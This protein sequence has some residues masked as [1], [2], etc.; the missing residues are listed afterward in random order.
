[1]N[2]AM[3]ASPLFSG[4]SGPEARLCLQC[5]GAL[6]ERHGKGALI[7]AESDPP[8]RLFVLL[9]GV[10]NVCRESAEGRRAVMA[11]I[12]APGDLFG[13]VHVFLG[14]PSYGCSV[15]AETPARVLAIP[16]RFF[17]ATCEKA[18]SVHSRMIRNMLGIFA[19][20][21]FFLTRRVSLLS[22]GSLRRKLAA[23][24]REHCRPDGSLA[25]EMNR[26]QMADFLGV[27]RPSLSRELAAMRDEGLI[28]MDG[29]KISVPDAAALNSLCEYFPA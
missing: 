28:D 10:V 12:D 8:E 26:E 4:M 27:A 16:G 14:R 11:R 15:L 5:S 18:C 20:K 21:A 1:M 2:R 9:E 17:Y 22:S 6:E 23:L 13:E 3:E 25:L 19:H 29:R 7:F 24:L